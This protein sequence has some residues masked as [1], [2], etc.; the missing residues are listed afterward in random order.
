[1]FVRRSK[2]RK[3]GKIYY[4]YL[5]MES[6]R[7]E[8][9]DPR[10][11]VILTLGSD[12][13]LPRDK[14]RDFAKAVENR[15]Y[16][17]PALFDDTDD[18]RRWVDW[19]VPRVRFKETQASPARRFAEVDLE[20]TEANQVRSL[21]PT[22]VGHY[23]WQKLGFDNILR[24]VG[25]SRRYRDLAQALVL[26]RLIAPLS[27]HATPSWVRRTALDDMIGRSFDRLVEDPLYRVSDALLKHRVEIEA[28]LYERERTLFSL[29]GAIFLWD[30]TSTY[31]EG[32][33]VLNPKAARGYSRDGRPDCKQVTIGLA[34]DGEGFP[35]GHE[36]F[37][38]NRSDMTTVSEMLDALEARTGREAGRLVVVDRGMASDE[39][40]N[41]IRERGYDYIVAARQSER[42]EWEEDFAGD[43][44][45]WSELGAGVRYK[46]RRRSGELL[47]LCVSEGR[48]KKD[49]AI[50]EKAEKR[51]LEG[52]SR[53]AASVEKGNVKR[54]EAVERRV[55]R[56]QERFPRA[57]K[58]YRVEYVTDDSGRRLLW[59]RND[60]RMKSAE[61]LDGGYIL[62]TSKTDLT[63]DQ[64]WRAYVLLTRVEKGFEYLK[65]DLGLR[66]V[67]HRLERRVD[68]HIFISILAYHIL[69]TIERT[70]R[71][72][73]DRRRWSTVR[74][75]LSTHI[76]LI[77][78]QTG[79]D[80]K[81]LMK[82]N[83]NPDNEQK[84][85]YKLLGMNKTNFPKRTYTDTS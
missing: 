76:R 12:F 27:E 16:G 61:K 54:R 32:S 10:N 28:A 49:R 26:N 83:S 60:E 53:L 44:A 35:L 68:G 15:L 50:R 78:G 57:A 85:I 77:I 79:K 5:L 7:N 47:L 59:Q 23:F 70:L 55:G 62:R 64:I 58:Y 71:Y 52:L 69:H 65:S 6:Y 24:S 3:R 67:Y 84:E 20:S 74:D 56:L 38:G 14:W 22:A 43:E 8:N 33:A 72:R 75:I 45:E 63:G 17:T 48:S 82:I 30:I 40:L 31:F 39:N 46:V 34:L 80:R 11:R 37:A 21:G 81:Y 2:S 13:D 42:G 1:M 25:L 9:G 73:G 36:V 41:T 66:P 4:N 51:F 18:I 29:D 19:A